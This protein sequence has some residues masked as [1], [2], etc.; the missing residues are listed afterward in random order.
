[1]EQINIQFPDGNKKAFD[2]GTTTEDIAQSI[3]P[4]LRKKAVA[5]KFNGQLVDLT[6]PLETDGSI[7]IVTP[8]SEEALEVLRHSTAHLMAHAIKRLYGNVK[9]G[10]GPVIEG[11]FYYDFDIDQNI[12][13]DDFEQIEKTMKQIVNENM[14]IER[15]VVSRDEAKELF[16]NDEYKLELIDA[17]PEDEN[18]TLYSQ[19]DFTDLCRGVHVPSTAKIK[20]F[21]L[22]STAGAYWRGDSN[23]KML[24]R[25][26]GTAFFD[27]KELKAHLQMLE[28]RKE[29]DHRKI[30]KELEL[31]TNSQL[32]GAG[33]PLW[34]PNGATI[35][36]EIERYIVDKEVSMGY[37]HVYTPVLAN[38][39][40]YK[41]SGH[42][43]HYQEDMFP[44]MQLDET[45]SMVLRPMN[46]PHHM[47]IYAN[48][49]HSYR[50][51]P[52]RI[53]ELGTMHRY[54]A[55]GAVSGLQRVRGMT[56]NDSHIF[57]RPDQ[58]KEEF[59]RVVNM[60]IDVYKDFGFEDYSFRLSYRDPE[61][62]EKYFDDD[63]MWNKAENMLKEAADE[64]GL[65][66]EEAIGEAA[67]Y[68]PKLDVQVKT[69]MGKEETLSTAQLD[70]LLPERF[71]LTYIGQDGE[72]H[73]PVVIHRG[74][75]STMERFVAFL[76]EETKG[77]FPTW[78]A[79]KQVQIIPVNV[80]L[81]YDY[82]RQLQDELK[83]QGVR[84]SID[85][86][87]E[88]MGYKIRE[89]Q[90]QKIPY[91]IVVGDKEVENNQVNVRQ[92]GSQDQETVEKDEFIWN[93][94]DEIRLKKHR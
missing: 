92:Y 39:D 19:G 94:V 11:G 83:S 48:K 41:T 38:V 73:R 69:A 53:A 10:V 2:K 57:V 88:K 3:S 45:E 5:G 14:K 64:L 71:D 36:R 74:V 90:M 89:A 28:E 6:K 61:D 87:N 68:G 4:G 7:E 33:L 51:L 32:V 62:K 82:A 66:Y 52:I 63:D 86:R 46:C 18:V 15:K 26:Y 31:F 42:W 1:M 85:D 80:D 17:I 70:F 77:A 81:H 58:I 47:M 67:F 25:I 72:H 75:V 23:N 35:R 8:G 79:P 34:L 20:E 16:S 93:L 54:E 56:L 60:I 12:S 65:S 84:V 24:Q 9:F 59:K 91:Q 76:T 78:L 49:P 44:P 22:L 55:S 30:G 43:D 21:K 29:R 40:L 13:S 27:K 37:D 50:E